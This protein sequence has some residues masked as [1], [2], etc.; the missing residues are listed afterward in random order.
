MKG[1]RHKVGG[2]RSAQVRPAHLRFRLEVRPKAG[3]M[4]YWSDGIMGESVSLESYAY[5]KSSLLFAPPNIPMFHF[6]ASNL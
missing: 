1:A 3:I 5:L 2:R 4:E 6:V